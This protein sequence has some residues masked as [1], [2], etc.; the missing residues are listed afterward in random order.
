MKKRRILTHKTPKSRRC[1]SEPYVVKIP[2]PYYMNIC[3]YYNRKKYRFARPYQAIR[4]WTKEEIAGWRK[5]KIVYKKVYMNPNTNWRRDVM[6]N[7]YPSSKRCNKH[8]PFFIT[9][10]FAREWKKERKIDRMY[11][12]GELKWT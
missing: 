11:R 6:D 7:V 4:M 2:N 12:T 8:N 9:G 10:L 3:R 5:H 1:K